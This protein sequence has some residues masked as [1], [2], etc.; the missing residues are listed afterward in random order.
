MKGSFYR[1]VLDMSEFRG[2]DIY[3]KI[4]GIATP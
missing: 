1:Y 3:E 2:L 4:A